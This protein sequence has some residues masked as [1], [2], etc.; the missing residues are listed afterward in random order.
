MLLGIFHTMASDQEK[1]EREERAKRLRLAR[2]IGGFDGPKAVHE[3]SGGAINVNLFKGH[4]SGRN[5]FSVSEARRYADLF[6]VSLVWLYLGIGEPGD[7]S[8]PGA[9]PELRR[10]FTKLIDASESVQNTVLS[11]IDFQL[12]L[13]GAGGPPQPARSD[14]QHAQPS[15]RH[16]SAPSRQR[17]VRSDA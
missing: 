12:A 2:D 9:N 8:L 11:F 7:A 1:F 10:A 3:A 6:G 16:G 13:V 17:S 5:G 4:Y 14:D 15:S